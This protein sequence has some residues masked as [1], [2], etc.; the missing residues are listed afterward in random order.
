MNLTMRINSGTDLKCI[1]FYFILWNLFDEDEVWLNYVFV[2][3]AKICNS[4]CAT[5][6]CIYACGKRISISTIMPSI[7]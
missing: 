2:K 6:P 7:H 5:Q 4:G 1:S 3:E